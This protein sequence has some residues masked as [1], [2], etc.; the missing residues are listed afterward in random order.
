MTELDPIRPAKPLR[1]ISDERLAEITPEAN[2]EQG[3]FLAVL[4]DLADERQ[5]NFVLLSAI[6]SAEVIL[7]GADGTT[8]EKDIM[9]V[10][11]VLEAA[12]Q[13]APSDAYR[14]ALDAEALIAEIHQDIE[15]WRHTDSTQLESM[16]LI[17]MIAAAIR[18]FREARP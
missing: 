15:L 5:Y 16:S 8:I 2:C 11:N 12:A 7:R 14:R 10:I 6:A 9:V 4:R 18:N 17:H 13:M 3:E 1:R